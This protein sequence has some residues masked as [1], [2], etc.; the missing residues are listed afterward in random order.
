MSSEEGQ[1]PT[2]EALREA[3]PIPWDPT[4][5]AAVLYEVR[6]RLTARRSRRRAGWV[7]TPALAAGILLWGVWPPPPVDLEAHGVALHRLED[8]AELRGQSESAQYRI[9]S[10]PEGVVVTLEAGGVVLDIPK[11]REPF[12]PYRVDADRVR[13]R[14]TGTRFSVERQPDAT[15]RVEV[16]RGRVE[17]EFEGEVV[18]L[19]S[20]GVWESHRPIGTSLPP[21]VAPPATTT[22]TPG[23]RGT[24]E[25]RALS[26]PSRTASGPTR[27][28]GG[29][30]RSVGPKPRMP[31]SAP[32]GA[33][34][35]PRGGRADVESRPDAAR[36]TR[37]ADA[38]LR[39][40][41]A[42]R[43]K[44]ETRRAVARLRDFIDQHPRDPRLPSALFTLGKLLASD[45]PRAAAAAFARVRVHPEAGALVEDALARE[46]I[47]WRDFGDATQARDRARRYLERFPSGHRAGTMRAI[48][49]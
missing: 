7:M 16:E 24:P 20:G 40:A 14:V 3:R 12:R 48:L 5:D 8:R 22:E 37:S 30:R 41:D 2:L 36:F 29:T 25:N 15:V 47:A 26:S 28:N 1:A 23:T 19:E 31:P 18:V 10:S 17:V 32:G 21:D 35:R 45:Q 46:A 6:K 33:P 43:A 4:R 39:A 27:T 13:V 11:D 38:L 34:A 44:G 49:R 9:E 42:A